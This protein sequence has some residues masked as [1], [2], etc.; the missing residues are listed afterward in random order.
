MLAVLCERRGGNDPSRWAERPSPQEFTATVVARM[1]G[2]RLR[3][4]ESPLSKLRGLLPRRGSPPAQCSVAE[5][6]ILT[7]R[8]VYVERVT[9]YDLWNADDITVAGRLVRWLGRLAKIALVA[10]PYRDRK[11]I[12]PQ[13]HR[14]SFEHIPHAHQVI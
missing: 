11:V 1:P 13:L 7:D 2:F 4:S 5:R 6:I 14:V 10:V 8:P 12:E 3:T 9:G